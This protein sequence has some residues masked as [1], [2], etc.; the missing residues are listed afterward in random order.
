MSK[1]TQRIGAIFYQ[2]RAG[3]QPVREWLLSLSETD[4]KEIGKDIQRLEFCWPVGMPHR[5]S[6]TRDLWEVRSTLSN[7]RTARVIFATEGGEMCLLHGF[8]KKTQQT[9]RH[10]IDLAEMR[11]KEARK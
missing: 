8:L 4:R 11:W 10:D 1:P 5:R 7:N 6:L 9:P 3:K 2:S